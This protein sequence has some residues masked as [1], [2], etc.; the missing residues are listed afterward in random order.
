MDVRI[1]LRHTG[2]GVGWTLMAV[3]LAAWPTVGTPEIGV[4][5]Q[6]QR[7]Q[8]APPVQSHQE[9]LHLQRQA[10]IQTPPMPDHREML[11]QQQAQQ[12]E[13]QHRQQM[14]AQA[15]HQAEMHHRHML[16][17]QRLHQ[18]E[19]QH[20]QIQ[21]R[22]GAPE[23]RPPVPLQLLPDYPPVDGGTEGLA[24]PHG[25]QGPPPAPDATPHYPTLQG[26]QH[27]LAPYGRKPAPGTAGCFIATAAY[28]SAMAEE[29]AVLREFRDKYLTTNPIGRGLVALYYRHSPPIARYI[30][31]RETL[32]TV[33]RAALLPLVYG[34]KHPAGAALGVLSTALLA[35]A[36]ARQ[37]RR[38]PRAAGWRRSACAARSGTRSL[39]RC[40]AS[41]SS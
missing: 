34:V 26:P 41:R 28:G 27:G 1:R 3:L 18:L 25:H 6:P 33:T 22:Y 21:Q 29:V 17:Q 10:I 12:L 7:I 23:Y 4:L 37:R 16:E 31:E 24:Q 11:Q 15:R 30:A 20:R 14:E 39:T 19:M 32:R 13:M 35:G 40:R 2:S 9:V 36:A 38:R 8:Q 5:R